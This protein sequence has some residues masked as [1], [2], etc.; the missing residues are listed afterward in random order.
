MKI[1]YVSSFPPTRNGIGT[2][3]RYLQRA[4]S[5]TDPENEFLIVADRRSKRVASGN[6]SVI[7]CFDLA[8]T[9]R[10]DERPEYAKDLAHVV[11]ERAPDVVHVQHG[12]SIFYP[13]GRFLDLLQRL[14]RATR[15]VVTLHA[16]FT[17]H[18]STW[19]DLP[20]TME[21]YNCNSTWSLAP[22]ILL[23][24][25]TLNSTYRQAAVCISQ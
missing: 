23:R 15:L 12:S 17:D 18:T 22:L 25:L 7:P 9:L 16:V 5:E 20:M 24:S 6:V 1:A 13:D 21:E 14:R 8:E 10:E 2:Y 19:Q 11:S 4:L 3:T